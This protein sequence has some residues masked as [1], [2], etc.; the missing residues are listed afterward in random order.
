M[1]YTKMYEAI[2]KILKNDEQVYFAMS[3]IMA[4][5]IELWSNLFQGKLPWAKEGRDSL[6]LPPAIAA[7]TARLITLEMDS[8]I[9]GSA[10]AI[11]LDNIYQK[12]IGKAR[13]YTEYACAKGGL[14][15]KPYVTELG[16]NTQLVQA[17]SFFPISFDDSGNIT[18]C[19]F[20]EQFRDGNAIYTRVE[21]HKLENM[22]LTIHNRAF[23]SVSSD[24]LGLEIPLKSVQRWQTLSEGM[25]VDGTERLPFGYFKIPLANTEDSDSP[26]GVSCYSRAVHLIQ[27]A[28]NRYSQ[29]NWEYGA[30]EAAV[31]IAESL[32]R[33]NPDTQKYELPEG[34]EKLYRY[35][36]YNSGVVEK[37]LL[38][39]F[40]PD[41]RD[42]SYFNGLNQQLRRVE[43]VCNLAYG[44]LS[45]PNNTDKTAEE[46]RASKQR[47]Y[48]FIES[49]QS[50]LQSALDD[51]VAALDFWATIYNLAPSGSYHISYKWDDSIVVDTEKERQT[52]R[53]DVAMGAMQLWE[54]RMKYYDEDMETA[55]RMVAKEADIVE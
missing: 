20:L 35:L 38:E 11:Y 28:D 23:Q 32:L 15:L 41:I 1:R 3:N 44:T 16:I 42:Q 29:I 46:I 52:D 7:E 25:E 9:T 40:S 55:K 8:K 45:D 5:R 48:S 31:H 2:A 4:R 19:V 17:D 27:E 14:I 13:I 36:E 21:Y 24:V 37:P 22:R 10:R 18:R 43:F 39:T 26:L 53:A 54:Y 50:A 33:K 30:K 51:Y 12:V 6:G 47:S 34:K 49:C